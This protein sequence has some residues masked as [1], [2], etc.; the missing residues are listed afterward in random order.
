VTQE[1]AD[2]TFVNPTTMGN[3][4]LNDRPPL[5]L[6]AIVQKPGASARTITVINNHLRS[7]NGVETN[8][9]DGQRVRAKR[10]AQAEYLA[11]LVQARQVAD[12]SEQMLVIG[13]FNTFDINDGY[14]DGI[15]TIKGTPTAASLVTLASPDLV[16]PNLVLVSVSGPLDQRYSYVFDGN[17]Q[18][19]DHVLATANLSGDITNV[20]HVRMNADF[21]DVLRNDANRMERLSDHDPAITYISLPAV[22]APTVDAGPDQTVTV[23][24]FGRSAPA[25][26]VPGH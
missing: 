4:L 7:L 1:G 3:D 22:P 19:I 25:H 20:T 15:A 18:T 12:P 9:A 14:V 8:D 23:N 10:R 6:K 24:E 2:A 17:A 11:N 26:R 16:N 21:P 5:V 13:D